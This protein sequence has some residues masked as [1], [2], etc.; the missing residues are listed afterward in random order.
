[1]PLPLAVPTGRVARG[2][3][4]PRPARGAA[5]LPERRPAAPYRDPPSSGR[6]ALGVA[7]L[8]RS[9]V[10]GWSCTPKPSA[11]PSAL[12]SRGD[13]GET[14]EPKRRHF[15]VFEQNQSTVS[16][17]STE[18]P[19]RSTQN[20]FKSLLVTCPKAKNYPLHAVEQEASTWCVWKFPL[21]ILPS[22]SRLGCGIPQ[23]Q[24]GRA[25]GSA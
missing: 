18:K 11:P 8:C 15:P 13:G 5:L 10:R 9:P 12:T 16:L 19:L 21:R 22:L 3:M 1:M 25:P 20:Y 4:P 14:A 6:G 23:S 2:P 17:S 7:G 24:H